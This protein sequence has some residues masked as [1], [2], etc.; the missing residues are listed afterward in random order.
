[1]ENKLVE[2]REIFKIHND[3]SFHTLEPEKQE[4]IL[5]ELITTIQ[6]IDP[7][8]SN[9]IMSQLL[10]KKKALADT[11]EAL[12]KLT[13]FLDDMTDDNTS[14]YLELRQQIGISFDEAI[15]SL[16]EHAEPI[17]SDES[18]GT[19]S[20]D[21]SI[22]STDDSITSPPAATTQEVIVEPVGSPLEQAILNFRRNMQD[23]RGGHD[24]WESLV[25]I[26]DN[27]NY[28]IAD[29][30]LEIIRNLL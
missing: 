3:N 4:K 1:M 25:E 27:L 22:T 14:E 21:E 20:S 5:D 6:Q 29:I 2:L 9:L 13:N 15:G 17:G 23:E 12:T 8:R 16:V 26:K 30:A 11:Q 7:D 24:I 10:E 19:D 18:T 28:E